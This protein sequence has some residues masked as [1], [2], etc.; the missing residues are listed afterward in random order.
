MPSTST[1][2]TAAH[3]R[4]AR[5]QHALG[6]LALLALLAGASA[7]ALAQPRMNRAEVD[8]DARVDLQIAALLEQASAHLKAPD[9]TLESYIIAR[10]LLEQAIALDVNRART[11]YEVGRL[12]AYHIDQAQAWSYFEQFLELTDE[13]SEQ[14]STIHFDLGLRDLES[15]ASKNPLDYTRLESAEAHLLA[16][17]EWVRQQRDFRQMA[18]V[19]TLLAEIASQRGDHETALRYYRAVFD[20]AISDRAYTASTI[21]LTLVRLGR[22]QEA[23]DFFESLATEILLGGDTLDRL[24]VRTTTRA[25]IHTALGNFDTALEYLALCEAELESHHRLNASGFG[26]QHGLQQY[27]AILQ[28]RIASTRGS[29]LTEMGRLDDAADAFRRAWELDGRASSTNNLAWAI[30]ISS[31][32]HHPDLE[33]AEHRAREAVAQ[34]PAPAYLDTLAE[35]LLRREKYDEALAVIEEALEQHPGEPYLESQRSRIERV[36]AGQPTDSGTFVL[37]R[38]WT[39]PSNT[40]F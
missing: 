3:R 32:P 11:Y 16:H 31:P 39:P 12:Y 18:R 9:R 7:T 25:A 4:S 1:P 23:H 10:G 28:S 24:V 13:R 22:P 8:L 33:E 37:R 34:E 15:A 5:L 21:A 17:Y 27:Y 20:H 40:T 30:A 19:E 36:R 26:S 35:V 14:W 6:L 2:S 29:T 38:P